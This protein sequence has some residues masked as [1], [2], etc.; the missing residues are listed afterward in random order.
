MNIL[1][2]YPST[3]ALYLLMLPPQAVNHQSENNEAKEKSQRSLTERQKGNVSCA[4]QKKT[5]SVQTF[6]FLK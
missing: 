4:W 2:L 1:Y 3:A 6:T 5:T